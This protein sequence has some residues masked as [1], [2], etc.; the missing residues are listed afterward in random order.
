MP[1]PSFDSNNY[2]TWAVK[3]IVYLKALDLWE[4]IE[5]DHDIPVLPANPLMTQLKAHKDKKTR[6]FK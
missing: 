4:A 1:P 2:Q 3:I 5:D 6:K